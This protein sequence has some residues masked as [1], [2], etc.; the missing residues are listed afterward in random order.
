VDNFLYEA[1]RQGRVSFYMTSFGEEAT[2]I[3]SAAA[4]T[5]D[6]VIFGQ[7]RETGVLMW[8]GFSIEQMTDQCFSNKKDMGKGR[9]MPVHYGSKE[10][11]FQTISSPLG[12]QIPQATGAGYFLKA[13]GKKACVVCYFGE[14]AA[15]EGD[16]HAG[17]NFASTLN[18]P[19]IFFCRNNGYAIST[20]VEQQYRG[21][22]IASRGQG[23]GIDTIRV[24]GNDI[25]AVYHATKQARQRAIEESCPLII[26]AM[27]YRVGHH[28]TSDDSSRYR[29]ANEV[30]Y[31]KKRD[32]PLTRLRIY[33]EARGWWDKDKETQYQQQQRKRVLDAIKASETTKKPPIDDLFTDVYD[34]IP[35]HLQQQRKQLLEHIAKYPKEYSTDHYES[36]H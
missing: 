28:S 9:Q 32:N 7:Y 16:F 18:S 1:Q 24:D 29:T 20:P 12:T 34:I 5:L 23:Y 30:D 33:M 14:G 3:G 19:T 26:E 4:L 36:S 25:W 27:T 6:D 13:S 22:G 11:N 2:H 17:L 8:R 21:D 31:W 10:L 15:S 35:P